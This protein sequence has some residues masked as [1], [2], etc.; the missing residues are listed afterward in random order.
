MHPRRLRRSPPG[1]P[2]WTRCWR[3]SSEGPSSRW[4]SWTRALFPQAG[5]LVQ[6]ALDRLQARGVIEVREARFLWVLKSRK[7]P[8]IEGRELQE[9]KLRI[10]AVLLGDAI[11]SPQRLGAHRPRVDLRAAARV[12]QRRRAA[13]PRGA[14]RGG[15]QPGPRRAR[16]RAGHRGGGRL[17][18]ARHDGPPHVG[19][20][21]GRRRHRWTSS[22]RSG[23]E[24][25]SSSLKGRLDF[26]AADVVGARLAELL[27]AR[28][29]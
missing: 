17:P 12:P 10:T 26:E 15:R 19:L 9:A 28:R 11:P 8:V 16:R 5:G 23:R 24:R 22:S 1:S 18:G 21:A 2:P 14:H 7:Y 27:A 3:R 13:P 29:G 20:P 25:P 6:L 4:S